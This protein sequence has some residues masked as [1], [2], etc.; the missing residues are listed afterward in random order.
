MNGPRAIRETGAG[1]RLAILWTVLGLIGTG[2]VGFLFDRYVGAL[3]AADHQAIEVNKRQDEVA[4]G[5][6]SQISAIRE[7]EASRDAVNQA[8]RAEVIRRL[9]RIEAAVERRQ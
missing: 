9:D 6:Q 7:L 8:H 3:E 2:G 5:L 1:A 4:V